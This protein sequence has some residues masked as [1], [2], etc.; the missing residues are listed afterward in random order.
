M[1]K[2]AKAILLSATIHIIYA[3][4][5]LNGAEIPTT[6]SIDIKRTIKADVPKGPAG[7]NLCWLLDSDLKRPRS[8]SFSKAV[9]DLGCG[10]LRFPYGHL[11]DNYLWHTA[12]FDNAANG[13]RPR[14]ATKTQIPGN[15]EWAVDDKGSFKS[16][17]DFD[18]YMDLCGKLE[19][20]PLVVINALSYKYQGGP[21]Y[22]EL[23]KTAVEW[24]KYAKRKG[25]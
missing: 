1:T 9:K 22:E 8:T 24:V 18:E 21:S 23:K 20:K 6:V 3:G 14:V 17:M 12:P 16:A 19:I 7:A 15:W 2:I 4:T 25:Y 13:L 11:A 5:I 10:S